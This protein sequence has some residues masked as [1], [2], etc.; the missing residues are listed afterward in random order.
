MKDLSF[1]H[2]ANADIDAIWD[3]SAKNW[4]PDQADDYTDQIRDTCQWL[5]L[6]RKQGRKSSIRADFLKYNCGSH[7][8]WY[9][10]LPDRIDVIRIL[11]SAQDVDRHL[12]D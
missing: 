5:A 4:G 10:D 8:I 11:H 9:R 6:G 12:H 1:S 2:R 3:Y 7:V